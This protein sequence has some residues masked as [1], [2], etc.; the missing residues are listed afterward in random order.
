M[1]KSV[2]FKDFHYGNITVY[3]VVKWGINI[4]IVSYI[5]VNTVTVLK[6]LLYRNVIKC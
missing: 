6:C 4:L 3:E 5:G 1:D 2:I